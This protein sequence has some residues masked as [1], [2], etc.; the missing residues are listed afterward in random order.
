MASQSYAN[1]KVWI[2]SMLIFILTLGKFIKRYNLLCQ[3]KLDISLFV[4]A[5]KCFLI[6]LWL[7]LTLG[8]LAW[9]TFY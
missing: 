7:P 2:Y 6:C 3:Q 5:W 1:P 4:Q 9:F 8:V